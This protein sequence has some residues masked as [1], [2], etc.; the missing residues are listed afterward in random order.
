MLFFLR[1]CKSHKI[2][3]VLLHFFIICYQIFVIMS[4]TRCKCKYVY[5]FVPQTNWGFFSFF[6]SYF[7]FSYH[8][9]KM[10]I[11]ILYLY[12]LHTIYLCETRVKK[13]AVL[14]SSL[15]KSPEKGGLFSESWKLCMIG[16]CC[17]LFLS[18]LFLFLWWKKQTLHVSWNKLRRFYQVRNVNTRRIVNQT[19][20]FFFSNRK[21][22]SDVM[23]V[24]GYK[25]GLYVFCFCLTR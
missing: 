20:V 5:L 10:S 24:V 17:S 12:M 3:Y 19:D 6:F 1:E 11:N 13:K 21:V 8:A 18:Y 4:T 23:T 2:L 14:C 7:F 25:K 15:E 22:K 16:P 9:V